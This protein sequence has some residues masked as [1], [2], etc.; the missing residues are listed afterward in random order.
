MLFDEPAEDYRHVLAHADA[1]KTARRSRVYLDSD[2]GGELPWHLV[3]TVEPAGHRRIDMWVSFLFKAT[4]PASGI[5]FVWFL[6][7][8]AKEANGS[9]YYQISDSQIRRTLALLPAAPREQFR[10]CLAECAAKVQEKWREYQRIADMQK[11]DAD[12]LH[13]L[14][15]DAGV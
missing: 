4:D 6:D 13:R 12:V 7:I 8:E 5:Q 14:A 10:T 3:T 11:R 2:Q 1:Y 15:A 9:G